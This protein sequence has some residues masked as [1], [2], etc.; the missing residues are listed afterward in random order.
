VGDTQ[1]YAETSVD[2]REEVGAVLDR[3]RKRVD[4]G[5]IS[6]DIAMRAQALGHRWELATP[7]ELGVFFQEIDRLLHSPPSDKA[8]KSAVET[9]RHLALLLMTMLER[10]LDPPQ[11]LDCRFA[12]IE[13]AQAPPIDARDLLTVQVPRPTPRDKARPA[14]NWH[15]WTQPKLVSGGQV[16]NEALVR[17]TQAQLVLPV[18]PPLAAFYASALAAERIRMTS[19]GAETGD[20]VPLVRNRTKVLEALAQWC[21]DV[22]GRRGTRWTLHRISRYFPWRAAASGELD[23]VSVALVRGRTDLTSATQAYYQQSDLALLQR[24]CMLFWRPVIE[25]ALAEFPNTSPAWLATPWPAQN[26]LDLPNSG[27]GIGS[28]KVPTRE[29]VRQIVRWLRDR[30][31][32]ASKLRGGWDDVVRYHNAYTL[33]SLHYL[34]WALGAR[35]VREPIAD[36]RLIEPAYNLFLLCDKS[37]GDL[38]ST[39]LV[40]APDDFVR[41]FQNYRAHLLAFSE[42]LMSHLPDEYDRYQRT[43]AYW[44]G[45]DNAGVPPEG[46]KSLFI[47]V[48]QGV[49]HPLSA[50]TATGPRMPAELR[51]PANCS[52]HYLR[53]YLVE[54]RCPSDMIDA[55]LGHW[56]HGRE[57]WGASS[58][59]APADFALVMRS[60][61][62]SFARRLGLR[63]RAERIGTGRNA[64][65]LIPDGFST[66]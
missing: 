66:R 3:A 34:L 44:R 9:N 32:K 6:A 52:R 63:A 10:G 23:P 53:T 55:Q 31:K 59:L 21:A 42:R 26:S 30:L 28:K 19:D 56:Y 5:A 46:I 24:R 1:T 14:E 17:E 22:N 12:L 60:Y 13:G 54:A 16:L 4:A 33:Y 64:A 41:H 47:E 45:G 49:F 20:S 25:A 65:W 2:S 18:V 40:W 27:P 15:W 48:L 61:L 43:F 57:P 8:P 39:R 29:A 38:Y 58:S 37:A 62:A 50:E 36:L 51:L 35:A 11:V 7:A